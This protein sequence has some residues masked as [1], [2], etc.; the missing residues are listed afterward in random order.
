MAVIV[1]IPDSAALAAKAA[2]ETIPIVFAVAND[3]VDLGLVDS[4]AHPNRN[5]TGVGFFNAEL[6][7]KQRG[8]CTSLSRQRRTLGYWSI[9]TIRMRML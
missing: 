1:A 6:G 8:C 5:A 2:T 4:L 7:S 3:P 9:L